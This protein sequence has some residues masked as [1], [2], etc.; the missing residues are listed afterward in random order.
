MPR[1]GGSGHNRRFSH[2]QE[3]IRCSL[4]A[5]RVTVLRMYGCAM[6][7]RALDGSGDAIITRVLCSYIG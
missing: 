7:L 4:C 3:L 1:S 5:S 2:Q 6:T